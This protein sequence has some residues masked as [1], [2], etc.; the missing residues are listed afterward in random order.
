MKFIELCVDLRKGSEAKTAIMQFKSLCLPDH[1]SSLD[2]AL[3]Y[4]VEQAE[5]RALTAQTQSNSESLTLQK[6]LEDEI[7]ENILMS[8]VSGE[9]LKDR[10][11]REIVT[12]WLKFLWETYRIVL[13]IL[14][15]F[16]NKELQIRYHVCTP[17][18]MTSV[19]VNIFM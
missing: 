19:I 1:A 14:K 12:P 6:D 18:F 17:L 7:P 5:Q 2:K 15:M 11:D 4:F 3:K 9:D 8:E 13:D 10:K 16:P